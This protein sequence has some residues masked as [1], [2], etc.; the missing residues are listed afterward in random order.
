MQEAKKYTYVNSITLTQWTHVSK[1]SYSYYSMLIIFFSHTSQAWN[2]R[3]NSFFSIFPFLI[4]LCRGR[5]F[6]LRIFFMIVC[7]FA[8]EYYC[9]RSLWNPFEKVEICVSYLW[10]NCAFITTLL[11]LLCTY[12]KLA[13]ILCDVIMNRDD[14]NWYIVKL[15]YCDSKAVHYVQTSVNLDSMQ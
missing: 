11:L 6:V 15:L 3:N 10:R 14:I 13:V 5:C 9:W 8:R 7:I 4:F 12:W 2:N 1:R